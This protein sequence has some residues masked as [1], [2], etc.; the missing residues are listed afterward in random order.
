M[1]FLDTP[2]IYGILYLLKDKIDIA[3]IE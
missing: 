2:I 3:D 1:A